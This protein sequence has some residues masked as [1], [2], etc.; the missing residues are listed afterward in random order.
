MFT[1][2]AEAARIDTQAV[3]SGCLRRRARAASRA[4]G[5]ACTCRSGSAPRATAPPSDLSLR[6]EIRGSRIGRRSRAGSVARLRSRPRL[7]LVSSSVPL[8]IVASAV[9]RA[10]SRCFCAARPAVKASSLRRLHGR[11]SVRTNAL[12]RL[13][14]RRLV[15]VA[16]SVSP[17]SLRV[18]FAVEHR[19]VDVIVG[20]AA[21]A[22]VVGDVVGEL[23]RSCSRVAQA[24]VEVQ[25]GRDRR[26]H[27]R[28]TGRAAGR[29]ADPAAR[30]SPARRRACWG[31]GLRRRCVRSLRLD[32][33][34]V[35]RPDLVIGG[36]L[37]AVSAGG[38]QLEDFLG[39]GGER[40]VGDVDLLAVRGW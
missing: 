35:A 18:R 21:L 19:A 29:I 40:A 33:A 34:A 30:R 7:S 10:R 31:G 13:S 36:E 26:W 2:R 15:S 11:A 9:K 20:V 4:S 27:R 5:V 6:S 12:R 8:V 1:K 17:A 25:G 28:G 22:P 3:A 39:A 32:P 16:V 38:A 37:D 23:A 14:S 24:R